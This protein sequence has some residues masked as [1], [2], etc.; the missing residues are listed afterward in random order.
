ML[1][2]KRNYLYKLYGEFL[3]KYRPKYFVFENVT[4]LLSA[5]DTDE[6]LHFDKMRA[7]FQQCGYKTEYKTL[8]AADYGVL[9]NRK[10]IILIGKYGDGEKFYPEIPKMERTYFVGEI[11]KDL[12]FYGLEAEVQDL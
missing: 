11:F 10:R 8:N 5:K 3:K 1:G 9:Q 6:K 12:P 4:G 7:L 2:D